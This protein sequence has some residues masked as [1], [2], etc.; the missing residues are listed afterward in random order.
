[1]ST[2][3]R[4]ADGIEQEGVR[5]AHADD[6]RAGLRRATRARHEAEVARDRAMV[7]T[8][9]WLVFGA[10]AGIPLAELTELAELHKQ[11]VTALIREGWCVV[12]RSS[13]ESE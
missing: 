5:I 1:M 4:V 3:R 12:T 13:P 8:Q 6:V 9:T 7:D 2:R 10:E 11:N